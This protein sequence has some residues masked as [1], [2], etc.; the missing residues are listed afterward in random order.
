MRNFDNMMMLKFWENGKITTVKIALFVG[1][2]A[3]CV[4]SIPCG[5]PAIFS[6]IMI[7]DHVQ[8]LDGC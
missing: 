5:W 4:R 3:V 8:T 6:G 2:A 1:L 7:A